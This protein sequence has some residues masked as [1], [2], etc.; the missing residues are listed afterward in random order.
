MQTIESN[1][2]SHSLAPKRFARGHC[3]GIM[4]NFHGMHTESGSNAKLEANF[5]TFNGTQQAQIRR[6]PVWLLLR[7]AQGHTNAILQRQVFETKTN[8]K[9]LKPKQHVSS[10]RTACQ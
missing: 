1:P 5:R 2:Q 10:T 3:S 7:P 9:Q 6:Y 8:H 4:D